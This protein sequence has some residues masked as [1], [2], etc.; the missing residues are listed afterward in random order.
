MLSFVYMMDQNITPVTDLY[1]GD[2]TL[3]SAYKI[4]YHPVLSWGLEAQKCPS[5]DS[6]VK[7]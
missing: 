6:L 7:T 4:N 2:I 1:R 5:A 3:H